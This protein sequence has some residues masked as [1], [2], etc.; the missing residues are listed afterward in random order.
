MPKKYH[1]HAKVLAE[2]ALTCA[3]L[4]FSAWLISALIE[5][6]LLGGT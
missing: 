1:P 4:T 3:A 6:L 5:F 2:L